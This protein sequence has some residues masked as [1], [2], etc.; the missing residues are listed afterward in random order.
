MCD[1]SGSLRG[2]NSL[3]QFVFAEPSWSCHPCGFLKSVFKKSAF[4]GLWNLNK[5]EPSFSCLLWG[6]VFILFGFLFVFFVF[7]GGF[8]LLVAFGFCFFVGFWWLLAFVS[9]LAFGGF[10]WLL[11][12]GGF[13]LLAFVSLFAF[14]GFSWLLA[15]VAFLASLASKRCCKEGRKEGRK[16]GSMSMVLRVLFFIFISRCRSRWQRELCDMN[17]R[18]R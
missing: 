14:G 16:E 3:E 2:V 5:T 12:F 11:A 4:L 7:A 1:W 18:T 10:S 8:W 9:L 17:T 13:W 6:G 15:F